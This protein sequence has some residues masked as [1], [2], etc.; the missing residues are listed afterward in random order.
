LTEAA[1]RLAIRLAIDPA[2]ARQW[3]HTLAVTLRARGHRVDIDLTGRGRTLP[4]AIGLVLMLERLLGSAPAD[5][6]GAA[7]P[8]E[9]LRSLATGGA[10]GHDLL[11]DLTGGW[12]TG[13]RVLRPVYGAALVEEAACAVLMTGQTPMIGVLD[14]AAPET[15]ALVRP[16]VEHPNQLGRNLDNLGARL[17][18]LLAKAADEVASGRVVAGTE[19]AAIQSGPGWRASDAAKAA[20]HLAR[21]ILNRMMRQAPHWFTGWRRAA[22]GDRVWDTLAMPAGGWTVLPDDGQRFYADPFMFH[23]NGR[24]WLFLE[25]FPYATQK[26]VI[27]VVEIGA[28]GPV[29]TPVP[30]IERGCHLSYPFVFERD[31]QIWMIPESSGDRTVDLYRAHDF[32]HGWTHEATLLNGPAVGD[33]TIVDH[34]GQLW[35]FGTIGGGSA[36]TWDAL[37]VWRSDRLES[38][39]SAVSD[40]PVLVDSL[41]A[42]PAGAFFRRNGELWRPAQDCTTGYGVGLALARVTALSATEFEQAVETIIRPDAS[43][44][45]G[46]GLH[47]LNW[48]GGIEVVDGCRMR[49]R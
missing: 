44:W 22:E 48:A 4:A 32:P 16:G 28:Q 42:R 10:A 37:H 40:H 3:H 7:W 5:A 43:N 27:S 31:G 46:I 6:A 25:D 24:D 2:R 26:G 15:P 1:R 30:I 12:E 34:G 20:G 19:R 18:V 17:A 35:M 38:G 49:R 13:G 39:W 21:R 33:A 36:S 45:P 23:H 41:G 14:S 29:G 47:T 8:E 11:I 9:D